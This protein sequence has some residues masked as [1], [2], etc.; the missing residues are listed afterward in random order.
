MECCPTCK[1]PLPPSPRRVC[2]VCG[3][4]ISNYHK[5]TFVKYD[6]GTVCEHRNCDEPEAYV[7]DLAHPGVK[8]LRRARGK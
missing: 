4:P 2:N 6:F 8:A 3:K 7:P 1:K 5:W